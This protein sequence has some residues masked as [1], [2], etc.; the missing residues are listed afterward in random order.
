VTVLFA[1]I[2]DFTTLSSSADPSEIVGVLNDL[3]SDFDVLA[4]KHGVQKIKTI[5]DEYM[6]ASGLPEPRADHAESMLDFALD[7]LDAIDGRRGLGGEPVHL[8]IGINSGPAVAGVIGRERF[9]YDL[10][11]DTVNMASRMETNG[12]LDRIQVTRSVVDLV[13]DRFHFE[14]REPILVKGK[15]MTVAYFLVDGTRTT[16]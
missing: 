5:G 7:L 16:A 2:V 13:G 10:W 6:A 1:D 14:E 8:R 12:Q 11:G 9:I 15:G 4:A 3:F